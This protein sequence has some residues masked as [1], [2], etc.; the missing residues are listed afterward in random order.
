MNTTNDIHMF[1]DEQTIASKVSD[2]AKEITRDYE[3]KEIVFITILKGAIFFATDL[4]RNV[5]NIS[6]L[7]FMQV[8]SY[9]GT[10]SSDTLVVKKD[11][12]SSIEGKHVIIVEDILDTGKTLSYLQD[13]L[14]SKNPSSVKTAVLLDKPSK[15]EIPVVADY[16]GFEIE[17][18]FVVGYGLD[19]NQRFRHL[20]YIGYFE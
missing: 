8:S 19:Y 11:L 7:D 12:D 2:M 16:V 1:M 3:G 14:L 17:D 9:E 20:P 5:P 13:Y 10:E 15:R 4:I 18:K 6:F